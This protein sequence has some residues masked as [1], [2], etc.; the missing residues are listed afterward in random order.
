MY[1]TAL[2]NNAIMTACGVILRAVAI[3]GAQMG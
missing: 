1:A 3:C 2:R